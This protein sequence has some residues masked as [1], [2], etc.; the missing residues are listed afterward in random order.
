MMS[1]KYICIKKHFADLIL[2]FVAETIFIIVYRELDVV[3]LK[4][5]LETSYYKSVR[6]R[7][8]S[9]FHYAI[10]SARDVSETHTHM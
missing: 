8:Y 10:I 9:F 3:M 5:H 1:E 7:H 4:A 6:F 2:K